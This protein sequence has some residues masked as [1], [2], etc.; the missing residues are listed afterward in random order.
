MVTPL[1]SLKGFVSFATAPNRGTSVVG[2]AS[3]RGAA[4]VGPSVRNIGS[5]VGLCMILWV[6][7]N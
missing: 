4:G 7:T 2:G 1:S 5:L 6:I 3:C